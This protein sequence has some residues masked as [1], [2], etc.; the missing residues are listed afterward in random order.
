MVETLDS[1]YKGYRNSES[2]RLAINNRY[3]K[4]LRPEAK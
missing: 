4:P 1:V 2:K 3:F